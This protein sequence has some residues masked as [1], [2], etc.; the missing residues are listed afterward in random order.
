MSHTLERL[1]L[2]VPIQ[3]TNLTGQL[4]LDAKENRCNYAFAALASLNF[5]ARYSYAAQWL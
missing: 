4:S 1:V 3:I 2:E 5:N